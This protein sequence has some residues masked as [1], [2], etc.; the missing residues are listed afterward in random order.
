ML[1][2]LPLALLSLGGVLHSEQG[3]SISTAAGNSSGGDGGR[4]TAAHLVSVEGL[5]V[6][7]GG[8]LYLA[9]A[10]GHRVRRVSRDGVITTAAGDGLPGAGGLN[11]P[12][13]VAVDAQGILYIADYGNGRVRAIQADGK[14]RTLAPDFRFVGPHKVAAD[15]NGNVY[16]SDWDAN[17]V[18]RIDSAGRV[19]TVM[20][21]T[22]GLRNPAGLAIDRDGA[23]YVADSGNGVVRKMTAAGVIT[24]AAGGPGSPAL[25]APIGLAFDPAG[26]LM[27]ADAG[28]RRIFRLTGAGMSVYAGIDPPL[29]G[30]TRDVAVDGLGYVYVA[31]GRQVVRF[32]GAGPGVVY[33]GSGTDDPELLRAPIG[34][35]MEAGGSLLIA[36][37]GARRVRRLTGRGVLET[38]YEG[39]PLTDP[40]AVAA[41]SVLGL[42]IADHQGNRVI[43]LAARSP[44][45]VGGDGWNRPRGLAFDAA[46]NLYVADSANNRVQRVSP[47]G[48]VTTLAG[49]GVQGYSGDGGPAASARLNGPS[50]V[51]V[52]TVGGVLIADTGNHVVRRVS[53]NGVITTIAGTGEA[54]FSGD[55][56]AATRAAFR[57]PSAVATDAAGAVWVADT[58]NH[59]VRRIGIDGV[60]A[61]VAGDGLPGFAGD[62]GPA[63]RARFRFP[64]S[65]A[66]DGRGGVYVA[67]LD[68]HR[69]RLLTPVTDAEQPAPVRAPPES[70]AANPP[71]SGMAVWNAA[72][73]RPSSL[74]PGMLLLLTGERLGEGQIE[75]RFDGVRSIPAAIERDQILAQAPYS[76]AGR[77][78]VELEVS[79]GGVARA[80]TRV[81]AAPSAPA[82]FTIARGTGQ[83]LAL[84]AD[85]TLNSV[86]N[87]AARGSLLTLYATGE[88]LTVP[89]SVEGTPAREPLPRPAL[90]VEV[91]VGGHPAE[92]VFAASAPGYAG[93][94]QINIRLPGIF[95]PPGVRPVVLR[96]GGAASQEGVTIAVQ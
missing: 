19:T 23:V 8:R 80:R 36:E 76:I 30:P 75:L 62:G 38:V 57:F 41:H 79:A 14:A 49:T 93:L 82:L 25:G 18:Y 69:I 81:P 47:A 1:I 15:G 24:T 52:D 55:G 85:G 32:G 89:P 51:A 94:L 59:R 72:S 5:A 34:L 33:A 45:P 35:A 27:I 11:T 13:G 64:S 44:F 65:L 70:G 22:A 71:V 48:S 4:A 95:S 90:P 29:S 7:P 12:Y 84:N 63:L 87:A 67:D 53:S 83:A 10:A 92:V 74:A 31:D 40:V 17:R 46:G 86:G 42:R 3:Y 21:E 78:E 43:G 66:L 54:G 61:T 56:G 16:V 88:G 37:E 28:L 77:R 39:A 58:F 68:N 2:R 6:D 50:G 9:D 26:N 20:G 91:T 73:L 60:V 96:V